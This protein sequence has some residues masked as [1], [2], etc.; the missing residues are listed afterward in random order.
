MP[1]LQPVTLDTPRLTLRWVDEGDLHDLYAIFSDPE[2]TRY[3]SA[4][5]WTSMDQARSKLEQLMHNYRNGSGLTFGAQSKENGKMIGTI[6][7]HQFFE[8]NRR[9]ELGYAF[10]SPYWGKGYAVEA[11]GAALDHA[12]AVLGL[13][14]IEADIDPR[15]GP[16]GRV[17]ERLGFRK[18]GYMPERWIV[19]GETAD[20]V[21]YGLLKRYW[22]ERPAPF[23]PVG[24]R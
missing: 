20:T 24:D 19:N 17:L 9:C 7:L 14:R 10:S 16:S 13:N 8:S 1:E 3:W 21:F 5:P 22:D 2:V 4:G 15:N 12:F 18:E 11:I 23:V 6:N